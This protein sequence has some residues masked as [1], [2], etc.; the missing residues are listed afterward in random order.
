MQWFAGIHSPRR[1]GQAQD[2]VRRLAVDSEG[3]H[4]ADG[5]VF[6]ASRDQA[7]LASGDICAIAGHLYGTD[8]VAQ[9][10]GLPAGATV[11]TILLAG[12]RRLGVHVLER[13]QGTFAVFLWD[14]E[15]ERGLVGQ[16]LTARSA[17]FVKDT[18]GGVAFATEIRELLRLLPS[19]PAPD[20]LV[21]TRMLAVDT[22]P[23]G[24]TLFADV[25][26]LLRGTC[27]LL[28]RDRSKVIE[29]WQPRY[30]GV[31]QL[32]DHDLTA[33]VREQMTASVER[34]LGGAKHAGVLLSGGLDSSIVACV[35][36]QRGVEVSGYSAAFPGRPDVDES[37]YVESIADRWGIRR[38]AKPMPTG[39]AIAAGL[40]FLNAWQVP[41]LGVGYLLEH[42]L[43]RQ[44]SH[45]GP[46]AVLDGQGGDELFTSSW[47]WPAHLVRHGRLLHSLGA[48]RNTPST[49]DITKPGVLWEMWKRVAAK[50]SLPLPLIEFRR[51]NRMRP[52]PPWLVQSGRKRYDES[53]DEWSWRRKWD[54]P[55]WWRWLADLVIDGPVAA[56]RT[57]YVRRRTAL[58]GLDGGSPLIDYELTRLILRMPPDLAY[59]PSIDRPLARR[60]FQGVLPEKVRNRTQKSNLFAFY[61]DVLAG[62]DLRWIRRVL[63]DPNC[64]VWGY[65]ERSKMEPFLESV[66]PD[67]DD[68]TAMLLG[69]LHT[70]AIMEFWLRQQED[71]SAIAALAEETA[72][73][74]AA[75][76]AEVQK[77]A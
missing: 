29:Y 2:A 44:M 61:R 43:T 35:A 47:F 40:D 60:S 55:L 62:P 8:A 64:A 39:G 15:H 12:F 50:P 72:A 36:A 23:P 27:L 34:G 21:L 56:D 17:I 24:R 18:P 33:L 57:D 4:C 20:E 48:I 5:P 6:L 41:V 65:V 28:E 3:S 19:R 1:E 71:P 68:D 74:A 13:L 53:R 73:E 7:G 16:D 32:P 37:P 75:T 63:G 11:S 31:L 67:P 42:T 58:M 22:I 52:T 69:V 76:S 10:L 70:A 45:D 9:E 14:A 59:D 77:A 51:R 30:E 49:S 46:M 66:P 26:R 54:G 25:R 38:V